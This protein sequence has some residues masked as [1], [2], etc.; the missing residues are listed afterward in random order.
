MRHAA[1]DATAACNTAV[2]GVRAFYPLAG[3][4][5]QRRQPVLGTAGSLGGL[6]HVTLTAR[7]E[8]RS[9]AAL[10]DPTAATQS[11]VPSSF[12]GAVP[13][14]MIEGALGLLKGLGGGL[15]SVD[16]LG[17]ALILPTGI[18]SLTVDSNAA[19]ISDAA[20]GLGFGARRRCAQRD[21]PIPSVSVELDASVA[22]TLAVRHARPDVGTG[23][24]FEFTMDLDA[25]SYRA[26]AGWKLALVD[27][28]AGNRIDHYKIERHEH[29][30]P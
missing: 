27:L 23:D 19:H 1:P 8:T 25:D 24:R 6:G 21:L 26:V 29:P 3:N 11:P 10:P 12:N 13:A 16:L 22:A 14:P 9:K 20:L 5:H 18:Q 28:A 2:D 17:S 30:V 15:L 4:D 7:S